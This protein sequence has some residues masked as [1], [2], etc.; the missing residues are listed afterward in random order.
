MGDKEDR[1]P[2]VLGGIL[3]VERPGRECLDWFLRVVA[4]ANRHAFHK[5]SVIE[6]A[7]LNVVIL[8][9]LAIP[10]E[11]PVL[12]HPAKTGEPERCIHN[13]VDLNLSTA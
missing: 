4:A 2:V 1:Q 5:L 13:A 10:S 8:R 7:S 3:R 9:M 11:K 12:S 6:G